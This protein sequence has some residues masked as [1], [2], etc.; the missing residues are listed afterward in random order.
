MEPGGI[1]G[2]SGRPLR[3]NMYLC[4][5]G[6]WACVRLLQCGFPG[7]R[8]NYT[9]ILLVWGSGVSLSILSILGRHFGKT[10][11]R[12]GTMHTNVRLELSMKEKCS[13]ALTRTRVYFPAQRKG[14]K[15]RL[16][17]DWISMSS[18]W[19]YFLLISQTAL[20]SPSNGQKCF[21]KDLDSE[22][23]YWPNISTWG[24]WVDVHA[25]LFPQP[26]PCCQ[27]AK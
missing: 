14:R 4:V 23:Y 18:D 6:S 12:I 26:P 25:K 24:F 3:L 11:R 8:H 13:L 22:R 15:G 21:R 17:R 2:S 7:V 9:S 10:A 20:C 5:L 27:E 19:C 16:G 1:V